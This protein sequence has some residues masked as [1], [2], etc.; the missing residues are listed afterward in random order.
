[1]TLMLLSRDDILAVYNHPGKETLQLLT[2][3]G[4]TVERRHD[5]ESSSELLIKKVQHSLQTNEPEGQGGRTSRASAGVSANVERGATDQQ[6]RNLANFDPLTGLCNRTHFQERCGQALAEAQR[7][8]S[9]TALLLMGL[10]NFRSLNNTLGY[11]IGDAVLVEVAQKLL[12][13]L[14]DYDMISRFGGDEFALMMTGISSEDDVQPLASRMLEVTAVA[15]R[16]HTSRP[17]SGACLGVALFPDHGSD[18]N[19]LTQNADIA[20]TRAKSEGRGKIQVFTPHLRATLVERLQQLSSF[21][22]AVQAGAVRPFYQPQIRLSDRRCYGFEAL[23][24]W[25]QPNGDILNPGQFQAAIEDPDAVIM[26]GEH[27][28]SAISDDLRHWRDTNMPTCKVSVNVTAPELKRGDYP[29]KVANLFS[30]KGVPLSQL[31]VEITE[32]VLLDDKAS[33]MARTLSDLRRLG[34]SIALDDFGTGFAS[35]SHLKSY[36]IDQIKIDRSF[37]ANLATNTDDWAIVRATLGLARS[38][39]IQT[40]AEGLEQE[41]QLK[42][43]QALGCDHGQGFFFSPAVP[44]DMAEAYFRTNRAYKKATLHQF[45]LQAAGE[46]S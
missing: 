26:L 14:H 2:S 16:Q 44:A 41:S 27:M 23:A 33:H 11:Q 24:R 3:C 43:L 37:I 20:L 30:S 1:M 29:E 31:T 46:A 34:V 36:A 6:L 8:G 7:A 21:H 4:A 10:D 40:V 12:A 38:L 42:C 39:G 13:L 35:L 28:L 17:H 32:S 22:T 9:K 25:V 5:P 19:E 45:V 15:M 18:I